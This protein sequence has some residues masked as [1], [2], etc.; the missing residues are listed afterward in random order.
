[1]GLT[2][3]VTLLTT[4]HTV[5]SSVAVL[6]VFREHPPSTH[7]SQGLNNIDREHPAK[8]SM[9]KV[10]PPQMPLRHCQASLVGRDMGVTL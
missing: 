6:I 3:E 5:Y 1:M 4:N 7:S 9:E 8:A 2:P 10:S